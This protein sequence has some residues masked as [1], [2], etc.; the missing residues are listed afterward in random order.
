MTPE[1]LLKAYVQ[2]QSE[3]AF[4]E[5]VASTLDEVYST[6]LRIVHGTPHLAE[7]IVV[8][9]YLEL[10]H[11]AYKLDKGVVL[12]SW[13]REH[14]CKM[15]VT[16]LHAEDRTVDRD[17]L[18]REKTLS[19]PGAVQP[20]PDGLATRI[21]CGIFLSAPRRKGLQLFALKDWWPDWIRRRHLVGGAV[22]VLAIIIWWSNP[23]HRRNRIIESQGPPLL[24]PSSFA[25]L[26]SP[27]EGGPSTIGDMVN[28][29]VG[30]NPKQK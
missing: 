13:L 20:A 22:C 29:N 27:D 23:F 2:Y 3:E 21:C 30:I 17:A 15:A 19:V 12:A 8:R 18:K 9:V 6:S 26:A 25:Q 28:T 24:A 4:R 11:K 14:A 16:V 10:A 7:E 5:L 1:I